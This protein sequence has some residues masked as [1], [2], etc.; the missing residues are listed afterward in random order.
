[1]ARR[2]PKEGAKIIY[3]LHFLTQR[4]VLRKKKEHYEKK[5]KSKQATFSNSKASF[6]KKPSSSTQQWIVAKMTHIWFWVHWLAEHTPKSGQYKFTKSCRLTGKDPKK[7]AKIVLKLLILTWR[8]VLGKKVGGL[9]N[10][11]KLRESLIFDSG[12]TG[13]QSTP[14]N[15]VSINLPNI[16]LP[17]W[18]AEPKRP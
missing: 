18:S 12:C 6:N 16:D 7:G 2:D 10:R 11:E 4:P 5:K 13:W 17:I 8:P 9:S 14:Q 15:L 1:M 3:R